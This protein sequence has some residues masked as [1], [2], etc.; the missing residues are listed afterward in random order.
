MQKKGNKI[1]SYKGKRIQP[2]L[3]K[4]SQIRWIVFCFTGLLTG[5]FLNLICG[6]ID[7]QS[8]IEPFFKLATL[9]FWVTTLLLGLISLTLDLLFHHLLAGGLITGI[10]AIVIT[11]INYYK[12]SMTMTPLSIGDFTLATQLG[13]IINLNSSAITVSIVTVISL[14]LAV[15]L[16][17]GLGV[18]SHYCKIRWRWSALG[19]IISGL[20]F[21]LVFWIFPETLF[22][23]PLNV[24][25]SQAMEQTVVNDYCSGP[26]LGLWRSFYYK[27]HTDYDTED[28]D[29]LLLEA[30]SEENVEND[31][32]DV[33]P[34]IILLMSESFFDV[35][36][37]E[38]VSF[39]EDPLSAYHSL[40]DES[41]SGTFYTRSL[42]YGTCDVELEVLTGMNTGLLSG[43][44]LYE[45]DSSV[46]SNLPAVPSVLLDNGYYTA[47]LHT[48]DD[49][50]YNRSEIYP[51]IGIE[52]LYFSSDFASFFTP[53]Q[54]ADSYWEYMAT[55]LS[56]G[57]YSDELLTEIIISKFEDALD[58]GE[59]QI[60][61][62]AASMEN[63]QPYNDDK[64]SEDEITVTVEAD[65]LDDEAIEI[66][67][68][69]TQG[70]HNASEALAE[71][72]DYF[73][74]SEEPTIIIF[75][76]DHR[77]GFGTTDNDTVYNQL[78]IV[79]TDKTEWDLED[80]AE[81][82]S[83]D[84]LIWANDES[85]LPQE[86]GT[87]MD[88][89][90]NYLGALILELSGVEMPAYWQLISTLSETRL[91]DTV[92]YHLGTDGTL[93]DTL[94]DQGEDADNL[95]LLKSMITSALYG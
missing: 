56:G 7:T 83:T 65:G 74:D 5:F 73:R 64:Y 6:M 62:F 39:D 27:T 12:V 92:S 77:P 94:P 2:S 54:E 35:T 85:L 3:I 36:E 69:F 28:L 41:V 86:A 52:N 59:D 32:S 34:N 11:L 57:Y 21:F 37:L 87:T 40:L 14:L 71:L 24:S 53:L 29:S 47:F 79:S 43:E 9:G 66:L 4:S 75:F 49:S 30:E 19:G 60:F 15:L 44:D 91:I 70:C 76:G 80:F 81:L 25:T 16:D 31:N 26:L 17:I 67:T 42:G 89:S 95:D 10:I 13:N 8:I 93:T 1:S 90:C 50:V 63:H 82:Y 46:F 68:A 61:L 51:N 33:T 22:F 20:V 72:V 88:T 23:K 48:Y 45:F 38:G 55:R 84:F 78:G 18:I 58:S